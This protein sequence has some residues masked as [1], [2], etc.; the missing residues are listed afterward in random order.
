[1]E[2][3]VIEIDYLPRN[4]SLALHDSQKRWI[5]AV[6]HRRAGKTTAAL[7]HLQRSAILIP[8]SNWAY[9]GPTYKQAKRIAWKIIKNASSTIPGIKYNEAELKIIYPN[10]SELALYGADNPDSLRGLALWGVVFDEYSQQSPEI[11]SE[12][13]TKC[14]ADHLGYAIFIGTFK[15]K[16]HFYRLYEEAKKDAAWL[17]IFK[18]IE[19]SFVNETGEVIENLKVALEDDKKLVA[20]GLMTQEEFDQEWYCAAEAAIKG[21][22]YAKELAEARKSKRITAVPY[23][24]V[25]LVHTVWDLGVGQNIA[26]GFYQGVGRERHMIDFWKG[27]ESEGIADAIAI[28]KNKGYIYGKHFAPHDAE[29]RE[30]STGKTRV[31]FAETFKIKFDIVKK[32]PVDDGINAGRLFFQRLWIDEQKCQYF[33]DSISQYRQE[34]DEDRGMFTEKPYHDWSSHG[35]D[36]HRYASIVAE[37]MD[38]GLLTQEEDRRILENRYERQRQSSDNGI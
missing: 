1:M 6:L 34:W 26:V 21:A 24:K 37:E 14:L 18:T 5:V 29:G 4:W 17:A 19:E 8:K 9:I 36:I 30:I 28:V 23:D 12:I 31:E 13:I 22:Y 33:L 25:L 2:T 11:F 27:K 32:I 16:N 35:A 20:Q 15:G 7:N 38:N 10:G 3:K